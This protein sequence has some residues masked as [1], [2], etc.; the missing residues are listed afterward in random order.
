[1]I[2]ETCCLATNPKV[3]V[4]VFPIMRHLHEHNYRLAPKVFIE[5]PRISFYYKIT[6]NSVCIVVCIISGEE[7]I[8]CRVV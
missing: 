6:H 2:P 5:W 8:L 1:M 4:F 3:F 7:S